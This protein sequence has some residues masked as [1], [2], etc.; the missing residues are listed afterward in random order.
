MRRESR[1]IS[2][3][4]S[5]RSTELGCSVFVG[6]RTKVHLYD[7]SYAWVPEQRILPKIHTKSSGDRGFRVSKTSESFVFAPRGMDSSYFGLF[8]IL[9][10][11][12][13][14]FNALRGCLAN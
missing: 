2:S 14:S 4:F 11:V 9:G 6:L 1:E 3:N 5:L 8:Y 12:W 13:L 10:A 7:E